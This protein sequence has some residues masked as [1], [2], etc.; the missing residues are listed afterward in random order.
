MVFK[1]A[2]KVKSTWATIIRNFIDKK[3]AQCSRTEYEIGAL[4]VLQ[5]ALTLG[6]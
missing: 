6:A 1:I 2:Q 4:Y 3:I 5:K